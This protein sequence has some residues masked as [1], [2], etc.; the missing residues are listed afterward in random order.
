LN[1]ELY[2]PGRRANLVPGDSLG[3]RDLESDQAEVGKQVKEKAMWDM[4]K[5]MKTKGTV[6]WKDMLMH[7]SNIEKNY[8]QLTDRQW[9]KIKDQLSEQEYI[10][11]VQGESN[12][13]EYLA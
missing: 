9:R 3:D 10:R 1:L 2:W 6:Q 8:P 13:Y 7:L 11:K 5:Y 12:T 4:V